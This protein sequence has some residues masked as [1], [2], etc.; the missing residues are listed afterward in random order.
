MGSAAKRVEH[1]VAAAEEDLPLAVDLARRRRAPLAVEN[2]RADAGVVLARDLAG[3]LVQGDEA[4]RQRRGNVHVGPVLAVRGADVDQV[5]DDQG[6][7]VRGVV[8]EDPEL[9]HHVVDPDD[10]GILRP[11]V[12]GGCPVSLT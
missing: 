8:R 1:A 9:V 5:A 2:A 3:L 12:A 7:A 11:R 6:R 10:V 4:R